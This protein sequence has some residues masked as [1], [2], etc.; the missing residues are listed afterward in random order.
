MAGPLHV[1][2]SVYLMPT[3]TSPIIIATYYSDLASQTV[4]HTSVTTSTHIVAT[5]MVALL[6]IVFTMR[7]SVC[8]CVCV[9]AWHA[10]PVCL[11]VCVC[12]LVCTGVKYSIMF[13]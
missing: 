3:L 2:A 6:L 9:C 5:F 7:E 11:C 10:V 8:V 1:C 4:S 13:L 12:V